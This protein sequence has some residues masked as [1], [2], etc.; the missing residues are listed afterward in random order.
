[1][2]LAIAGL[3][4]AGWSIH[5]AALRGRKDF[6]ITDVVDLEQ[7]RL[8]EARG[9]FSCRT[10]RSWKQFL[11]QHGAEMVV[12]ATR[13]HDHARMS[14]DALKAGLHVLVEKPMATRWRDV[15]RVITAARENRRLLTVH[16]NMRLYPD[17]VHI[18]QVVR[19]GVLGRIFMIKRGEYGF[20]RRNDWQVFRKYGGGML[21]NWAVHLVDQVLQVMDSPAKDVFGHIQHVLNP[22]DADDHDAITIRGESGQVAV[23]EVTSVCSQPLPSWVLMGTKGTLVGDEKRF[24]LRYYRKALPRVAPVDSTAVAGRRYGFGEQIPWEEET[25]DA[26]VP[27]KKD[28]YDHLYDSMRKGKPLFVSPE[29]VRQTMWVLHQARRGT[30]FRE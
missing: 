27:V 21:N 23:V 2:R 5:A 8:A 13:S 14:I 6:A 1:V 22:G 26:A 29:S 11:G 4:R 17:F 18:Q 16:Q 7:N 9:E 10:H 3:G 25:V 28:F 24:R 30:L 12:V 20:S 19:S 15:D